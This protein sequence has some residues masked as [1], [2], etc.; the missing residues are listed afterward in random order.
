MSEQLTIHCDS[1]K[2]KVSPAFRTKV[3]VPR[4]VLDRGAKLD[5]CAEC[6]ERLILTKM[7][8]VPER[9]LLDDG[10]PMGPLSTP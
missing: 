6:T 10:D 3:A 9:L 7:G 8:L 2:E 4:Q 5:L 1:C